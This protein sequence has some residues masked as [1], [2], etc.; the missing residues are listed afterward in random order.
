VLVTLEDLDDSVRVAACTAAGQLGREGTAEVAHRVV[1]RLA[2]RLRDQLPG[3]RVAAASAMSTMWE[4]GREAIPVLAA[5]PPDPDESVRN[6]V[7]SALRSLRE[8]HEKPIEGVDVL[9]GVPIPKPS[10]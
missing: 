5:L 6:A 8:V 1:E 10:I 3:V 2:P 4:N 7:A 9:F